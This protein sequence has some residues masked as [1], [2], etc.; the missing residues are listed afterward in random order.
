MKDAALVLA[1][2]MLAIDWR[3]TLTIARNPDK[4][5]EK[6]PL[7]RWQMAKLGAENGVNLHFALSAVLISAVYFWIAYPLAWAAL[8]IVLEGYVC[9]HNHRL[10]IR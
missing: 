10:G 3:Q 6:N 1:L 9:L 8:W 5:R 4:W 7:I 2:I